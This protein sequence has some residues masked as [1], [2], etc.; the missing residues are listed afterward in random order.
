MEERSWQ[1][2]PL[3]MAEGG[4]DPYGI[5]EVV[6]EFDGGNTDTFRPRLREE[7]QSYEL[8]MKAEYIHSIAHSI[9]NSKRD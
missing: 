3:D 4:M 6:F 8:H 1:G 9:R 5:K 7:V 2:S